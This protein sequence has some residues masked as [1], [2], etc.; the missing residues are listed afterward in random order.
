MRV[1]LQSSVDCPCSIRFR[2]PL[3][4]ALWRLAILKRLSVSSF[5]PVVYFAYHVLFTSFLNLV[6]IVMQ[7]MELGSGL[8]NIK[9]IM[10]MDEMKSGSK[11]LKKT[12]AME[13]ILRM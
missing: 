6:T 1:L 3:Y 13:L 8:D 10:D 9:K 11:T 7:S 5:L 12:A 2:H 4:A